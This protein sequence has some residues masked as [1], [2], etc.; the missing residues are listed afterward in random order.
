MLEYADDPKRL[1][2]TFLAYRNDVDIYTEDE[3]KDKEF[4]KAL[5]SRLIT[6]KIKIND[7]TPLGSKENVITQCKIS[8]PGKRKKVFI[9]DGDI[10]L[11]N[12][13]GL[14]LENLFVLERYCIENFLI[15]KSS[16]CNFVYLNCGTKSKEEIEN[17]IDY[18]FWLKS[19]CNILIDL[20]LHFSL[21]NQVG[22]K[23]T[24]YNANKYH[25]LKKGDYEFDYKLVEHD[26]SNIRKEILLIV[27]LEYYEQQL[28]LL[29]KKWSNSIES[30]L[31][32]VS[33]KD[34]LIP[35][36][37]IKMQKFKASKAMPSLEEVKINLVNHFDISNLQSLKEFIEAK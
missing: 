26:I 25:T 14:E 36:L 11:I 22:G 33:G 12:G 32:I 28:R 9:V 15:D 24:L 8:S 29:K 21:I 27:D 17:E 31:T 35:I 6:S 23:F 19:Y 34:Y 30:L 1:V 18:E 16:T 5:F 13:E 4:Y 20:F 37:L 10:A 3:N 7:V 2:S